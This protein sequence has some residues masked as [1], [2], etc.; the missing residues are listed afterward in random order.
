VEKC[1]CAENDDLKEIIHSLQEIEKRVRGE[2][3][4]EVE[5]AITSARTLL[6]GESSGVLRQLDEE[7]STWQKKL[8]VILKEPVGREGMAKHAKHWVEELRKLNGG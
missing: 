8:N 5:T 2:D 7:L 1:H 6:S 3:T 4:S